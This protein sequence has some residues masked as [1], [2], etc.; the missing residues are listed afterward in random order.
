MAEP[1]AETQKTLIAE[2]AIEIVNQTLVREFELEP[3]AIQPDAR[4]REDLGLDS[5]DAV[6]LIVALEKSL[7]VQVP[8]DR[9]RQMRTVGDIYT[10]IRQVASS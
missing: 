1:T 9:A 8:E 6:D 3:S 5:L 10:Y 7:G 2:Q 4:M